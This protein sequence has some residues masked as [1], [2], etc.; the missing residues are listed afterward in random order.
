V[1]KYHQGH[2]AYIF[3]ALYKARS[4]QV[5][6]FFKLCAMLWYSCCALGLALSSPWLQLAMPSETDGVSSFDDWSG[7]NKA[8]GY[9]Y[10]RLLLAANIED[11][12][13]PR[14]LIKEVQES[15]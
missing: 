11:L 10:D 8:D 14:Q 3:D 4:K 2:V 6:S 7:S 1:E 15:S 9:T 12:V 5:D 13:P